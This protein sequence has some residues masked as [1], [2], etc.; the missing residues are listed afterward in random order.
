MNTVS[1]FAPVSNAFPY[2]PS[3][4]QSNLTVGT[5]SGWAT[6]PERE[7][8]T[9]G[10]LEACRSWESLLLVF[11]FPPM[12]KVDIVVMSFLDCVVVLAE[13]K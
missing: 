11:A 9:I 13:V 4:A 12:M 8:M 3:S 6:V 1:I 7:P 5:P 2:V 10:W